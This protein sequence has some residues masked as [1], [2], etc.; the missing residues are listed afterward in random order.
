MPIKCINVI[1]AYLRHAYKEEL[2][3]CEV[4]ARQ[5]E[6]VFSVVCL[7]RLISQVGCPHASVVS[8]VLRQCVL[9]VYLYIQ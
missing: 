2:V 5:D 9:S 8:N 1:F 3:V 4:H 7:P 6:A